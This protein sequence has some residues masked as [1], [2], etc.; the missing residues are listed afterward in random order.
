[1]ASIE[2]GGFV[3]FPVA[4]GGFG[5]LVKELKFMRRSS[6]LS[7]EQCFTLKISRR[8]ARLAA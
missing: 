3:L 7:Q 6:I 2:F 8:N 5:H 4:Q 1:M